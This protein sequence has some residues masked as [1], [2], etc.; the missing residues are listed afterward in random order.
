MCVFF[1]FSIMKRIN[2]INLTG[3][4]ILK[5]ESEK[6]MHTKQKDQVQNPELV[7]NDRTV[8]HIYLSSLFIFSEYNYMAN[9]LNTS[10]IC[11]CCYYFVL[12]CLNWN[13]NWNWM[14]NESKHCISQR[15][16]WSL[17]KTICMMW[18][19]WKRRKKNEK[20]KNQTSHKEPV[21][22]VSAISCVALFNG[23]HSITHL[24]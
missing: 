14:R 9:K 1:S 22:R 15:V 11:Y 13:S 21:N 23:I 7:T 2:I 24:A 6:W 3:K 8:L 10:V 16:K 19:W 20:K 12:F 17:A 4:R 18:N 5:L